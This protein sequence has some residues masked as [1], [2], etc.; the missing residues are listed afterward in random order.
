M[1]CSQ[2]VSLPIDDLSRGDDEQAIYNCIAANVVKAQ[3]AEAAG[4]YPRPVD[5]LFLRLSR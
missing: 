2:G 5:D 3:A 1:L 4:K